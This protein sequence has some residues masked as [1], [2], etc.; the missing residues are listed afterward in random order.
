MNREPPAAHVTDAPLGRCL[1]SGPAEGARAAEPRSAPGEPASLDLLAVHHQ[2]A[3]FVW[4]SLQRLGVRPPDLD[5][6]SQE[7]FL[8]VHK[9]LHTFD[10]SSKLTTWLFGICMRVATAHRRRAWFR[11][12][13]PAAELPDAGEAPASDRPDALCAAREAR[14]TLERVL[15]AMDLDKR[16]VFVMFEIDELPSEEIAG[17]L[18]VPVGTVWSRLSAARKQ[19]EAKL[20]R[21]KRRARGAF[22]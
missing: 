10:G 7:V 8:V 9:R 18:G 22:S 11:R 6:V 14:A 13:T 17:I 15:D 5:D 1:V 16:A 12:E 19:F 4:C 21:E 2:H 3:D 20:A